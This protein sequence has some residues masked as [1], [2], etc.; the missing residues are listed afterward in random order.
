M[1]HGRLKKTGV[2]AWAVRNYDVEIEESAR[3]DFEK[4]PTGFLRRLF[5]EHGLGDGPV[6][7]EAGASLGPQARA[8]TGHIIYP[9]DMYCH[10]II[11]M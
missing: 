5:D 1:A 4:D 8:H 2:E 6:L 3:G 9:R 10:K 7:M 11:V